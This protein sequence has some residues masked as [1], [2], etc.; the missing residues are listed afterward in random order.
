MLKPKGPAIRIRDEVLA[1]MY[2]NQ[3]LLERDTLVDT[4]IDKLSEINIIINAKKTL[5]KID[6]IIKSK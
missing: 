5:A 2:P 1:T 3:Y 6:S 4:K